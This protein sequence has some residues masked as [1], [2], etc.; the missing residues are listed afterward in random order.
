MTNVLIV[1]QYNRF[2]KNE[3]HEKARLMVAPYYLTSSGD[4]VLVLIPERD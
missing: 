4:V 1:L 2:Y 3:L